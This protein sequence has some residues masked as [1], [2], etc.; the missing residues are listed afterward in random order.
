MDDLESRAKKVFLEAVEQHPRSEWGAFLDQTCGVDHDLRYRVTSLLHAHQDAGTFLEVCALGD[1]DPADQVPLAE[2]PGTV[3]GNYQL[4]EV[5][6]EGGMG[7]VFAAEQRE[8]LRRLVAFKLVRPGMDSRDVI[9]RFE[10][11]RQAL[12]LMNHPHIA[13]VLDAGTT[14]SGRPYFVM[15]LVEGIP[16][17]DYCCRHSL[18]LRERLELF[19]AVCEAVQHAH[20]KGI[21]HRD[22]K[23][24]NVMVAEQANRPFVKVIDFGVAKAMDPQLAL[25]RELGARSPQILGTPL[26]MSPEQADWGGTDIDT[27]TDIYSL[28][29]LLYELLTETTPFDPQQLCGA[30]LDEIRRRLREEDPPRPSVR[31]AACPSSA[32]PDSGER[33]LSHHLNRIF[34]LDLDWIV[35]KAMEKDRARRYETAAGLAADVARFLNN[36][37]VKARPPST[38]Y[39]CSKFVHRNF[40]S[41]LAVASLVVSAVLMTGL[42][43][44]SYSQQL[45]EREARLK[46]ATADLQRQ[47]AELKA[48]RAMA[49]QK[50]AFET[51]QQARAAESQARFEAMIDEALRHTSG[52]YPDLSRADE[53]FTAAL[54]QH[55][56]EARL[57]LYRG[58]VRYELGDY[59]GAM[60]DLERA[61]TLQPDHNVSAHCLLALC[62]QHVGDT[63]KAREHEQA[64]REYEPNR[65]EYLVVQALAIPYEERGITLL[66]E[67]I[68]QRPFDPLLYFYRGRA[69]Y[70][71]A[72]RQGSKHMVDLAIDD[73]EKAVLGRADDERM[74]ELLCR[75][76]V[77]F[78][79]LVAADSHPLERAKRHLDRWLARDPSDAT[80]I[81]ILADWSTKSGNPRQGLEFCHRGLELDPRMPYLLYQVGWIH[82]M[83]GDHTQAV[84]SLTEALD[85]QPKQHEP[86]NRAAVMGLACRAIS[87]RLLG[88]SELARQDLL[89]ACASVPSEKWTINDWTAVISA[90]AQLG[91]LQ[92]ALSWA[93]RFVTAAPE[94][95]EAR[96]WRGIIQ[97]KIGAVPAARADFLTAVHLNPRNRNAQLGLL[98]MCLDNR[99]FAAG[100]EFADAW[101]RADPD[102]ADPYRWR[103][104]LRSQLNDYKAALPDF[105]AALKLA[106]QDARALF[107]RGKAYAALR[108]AD[109][110][111]N[112]FNRALAITPNDADILEERGR[113]RAERGSLTEAIEDFAQA[114]QIDARRSVA[115]R[116]RGEAHRKL[117]HFDLAR[118]DFS[119]A[120]ELNPRDAFSYFHRGLTHAAQ[121]NAAEATADYALAV[122]FNSLEPGAYQ[123][124]VDAYI[125]TGDTVSALATCAK[126]QN[127][128]PKSSAPAVS[129][130]LTHQM[131]KEYTSALAAFDEAIRRD[132]DDRRAYFYRGDIHAT[133]QQYSEALEDYARSLDLDPQYDRV[134]YARGLLHASRRRYQLATEDLTRVMA[135]RPDDTWLYYHRAHALLRSDR[136]AAARLDCDQALQRKPEEA[137]FHHL[138]ALI[139]SASGP[140]RDAL[141]E[142]QRAA[143]L[144]P[145]V[146]WHRG[147]AIETHLALGEQQAAMSICDAWVASN[148]SDCEPHR[149][150]GFTHYGCRDYDRALEDYN[151]A[152]QLAPNSHETY[153]HR[154]QLHLAAQRFE[155]AK[156]DLARCLELSPESR[157]G[158]YHLMIG[159]LY[160]ASQQWDPAQLHVLRAVERDP[161]DVRPW[162]LL[163]AVQLA[164]GDLATYKTT[165]TRALDRFA[166]ERDAGIAHSVAFLCTLG[167]DR[168]DDSQ[169][170]VELAERAVVACPD[171]ASYLTT[172][173]T[174]LFQHGQLSEARD[175]LVAA[176]ELVQ[177]PN[178]NRQYS[179][180]LTFS[181]LAQLEERMAHHEEATRL[182]K[183]AEQTAELPRLLT[184]RVSDDCNDWFATVCRKRVLDEARQ[185]VPQD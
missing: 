56:D 181:R 115:W 178:A 91:Q 114:I 66:D 144:Q 146:Y 96:A 45:S 64:A 43:F 71:L 47:A 97:D 10:A 93:N 185:A 106:P 85:S 36:E 116:R 17:T 113:L 149:A 122:E 162:Q 95:T 102:L 28:G 176:A 107:H 52:A 30:G 42:S 3:I 161:L 170:V 136:A 88:N 105:N 44:Y 94:C 157:R 31:I 87:H 165:C 27:R 35:M 158:E 135:T 138:L 168:C 179:E 26:Y 25:V 117:G 5:I 6:G 34:R 81:S 184:E 139:L 68:R 51:A 61:V 63:D 50:Q 23:P 164:D 155:M 124:L 89:R 160:A 110:A 163:A 29:V 152:L 171:D 108:E 153:F 69:A 18:P 4:R 74:V 62:A 103:G 175:R 99:E 100:V 133:L 130:G 84:K 140:S 48:Q 73:L 145:Q 131:A 126:W 76:L 128:E 49:A 83:L 123:K 92:E 141:A 167:G 78:H 177:Q 121:G 118:Q 166:A 150:R 147:S 7:L 58:S 16:I 77:Q 20:Q 70:N 21:V 151:R 15:E 60:A 8:P 24:S 41:V 169:R 127:Q 109:A 172:L 79:T 148:P 32:A 13:Q 54:Q 132:P 2:R 154:G 39:R 40:G 134:Y 57:Y 80:A 98:S 75:C 104:L 37:P 59:D 182:L 174:A 22:I 65:P 82:Q 55:N 156:S 72:V 173:G 159:H 67:V 46:L 11:E 137:T 53:L 14:E 129:R 9:S 112:D 86:V 33:R 12:A 183:M 143:S 180:S 120:L 142:F 19:T 90:H 119:Q 38:W 125:K 111:L 1:G 101:V